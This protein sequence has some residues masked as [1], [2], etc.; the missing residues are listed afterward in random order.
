MSP[1]ENNINVF[2]FLNC[3]KI[4]KAIMETGIKKIPKASSVSKMNPRARPIKKKYLFSFFSNSL[5]KEKIS[6][7]T[8]RG[9]SISL[10]TKKAFLMR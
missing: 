2:I 1:A 8:N 10:L 4:N 5:Y 6:N 9:E 3:L 7:K